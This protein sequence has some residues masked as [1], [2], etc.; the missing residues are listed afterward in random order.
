MTPVTINSSGTYNPRYGK[1]RIFISGAGGV[2]TY[3]PGNFYDNSYTNSGYTNPA[4]NNSYTNPGSTNAAQNGVQVGVYYVN[5]SPSTWYADASGP[6]GNWS[7]YYNVVTQSVTYYNFYAYYSPYPSSVNT[8]GGYNMP[9]NG[10]TTPSSPYAVGTPGAGQLYGN[11]PAY[12]QPGNY[13]PGNYDPGNYVPGNYVSGNTGTNAGTTNTGSTF[14]IFGV[15][16]PGG[17][18]GAATAIPPTL[19]SFTSYYTSYYTVYDT[20]P[21]TVTVPTGGYVIITFTL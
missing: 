9:G 8:M 12:Y 11:V 5:W 2:G 16:L 21:I 19:G 18:G 10:G 1:Q 3:I 7:W 17:V 4:V 13:V 14:N 6:P 20:S 15:S